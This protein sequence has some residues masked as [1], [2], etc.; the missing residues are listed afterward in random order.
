MS[1]QVEQELW[2]INFEISFSSLS[3]ILQK[4][5]HATNIGFNNCSFT[6]IDP[7]IPIIGIENS[8]IKQLSFEFSVVKQKY[9]SLLDLIKIIVNTPIGESIAGINTW[10]TKLSIDYLDA[11]LLE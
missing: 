1:K 4:F 6:E 10:S 7:N 2:L 3:T 8:L 11:M 5:N 9:I